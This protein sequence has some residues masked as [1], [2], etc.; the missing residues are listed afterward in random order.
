VRLSLSMDRIESTILLVLDD[1]ARKCGRSNLVWLRDAIVAE[2]TDLKLI[3]Q[4]SI[5]R[6]VVERIAWDLAIQDRF[7]GK[8]VAFVER[9]YFDGAESRLERKVIASSARLDTL[10]RQLR[11]RSDLNVAE[12]KIRYKRS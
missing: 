2:I 8:F 11:K 5:P 4:D 12:L 6:I 7:R 3:Y 1:L 9:E 10:E